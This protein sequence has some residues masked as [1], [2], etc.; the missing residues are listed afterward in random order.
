[1]TSR[2][3]E[4]PPHPPLG[5]STQIYVI[6]YSVYV[7]K[8]EKYPLFLLVF[9]EKSRWFELFAYALFMM[10]IHGRKKTFKCKIY[11]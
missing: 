6:H 7:S 5:E 1:V 4:H 8:K 11:A 10:I 2:Q 3:I 9:L